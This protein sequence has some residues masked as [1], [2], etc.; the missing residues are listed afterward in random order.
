MTRTML[1]ILALVLAAPVPAAPVPTHLMPETPPYYPTTVGTKWVYDWNGRQLVETISAVEH[2]DGA[3]IITLDQEQGEQRTQASSVLRLSKE[4]LSRLAV[5][6]SEYTEPYWLLKAP[7]RP[8]DKWNVTVTFKPNDKPQQTGTKLIGDADE[9]EVMGKKLKAIRVITNL[10]GATETM[11]SW[12]VPGIGL[13]K[14][15]GTT[16]MT[17]LS[18]TSGA[19]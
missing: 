19:K 10:S 5:R 9:I 16:K 6:G 14:Q 18:F 4:G 7:A 12:Y 17:L 13:V 2:K 15:T 1:V 11:T 8:G 3:T